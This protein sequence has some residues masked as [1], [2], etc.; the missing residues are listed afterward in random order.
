MKQILVAVDFSPASG[1]VVD[2]AAA[3]AEAHVVDL[4]AGWAAAELGC[5]VRAARRTARAETVLAARPAVA[6]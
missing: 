3:V 1:A 5:A 6:T 4:L 2:R